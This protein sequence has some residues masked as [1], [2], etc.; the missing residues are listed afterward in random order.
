MKKIAGFAGLVSV[1]LLALLAACATPEEA[2]PIVGRISALPPMTYP[3]DNPTSPAKI[4]LGK[5]LF[6]D[7]RLSGGGKAACQ[8]AITA[9]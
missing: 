9:I 3:A 6:A 2:K 4:A 7:T 8:A 5:Q 1:A